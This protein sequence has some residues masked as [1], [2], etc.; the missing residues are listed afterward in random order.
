MGATKAASHNSPRATPNA[1]PLVIVIDDDSSFRRSIQRLIR[2]AG[3]KVVVFASA[4]DYRSSR[5]SETAACLIL[6][7]RLPGVSGLELQRQLVTAGE[8]IP[9]IFMTGHGDI[10]M[11]VKAMKA[12]AI[13]FLTKPFREQ[14]LLDALQQAIDRDLAARAEKASSAKLR[15]LYNSLTPR[16]REVM[17]RVVSGMLNKQI[18]AELG[19]AEKTIKFH[20]AHIMKKMQARSFADLVRMGEQLQNRQRNPLLV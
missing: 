3:F 12:G 6:D 9:I 13:E 18:A 17:G 11:S 20:R 2:S 15:G 19:T 8:E 4:E 7:V 5:S 10:P 16:E 1:D 14:E